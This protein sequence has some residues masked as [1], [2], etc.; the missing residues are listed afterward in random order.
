MLTQYYT[1]STVA[2][3]P[4]T[5]QQNFRLAD[6]VWAEFGDAARS[7]HTDRSRLIVEFIMWYLRSPN[8]RLPVRPER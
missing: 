1:V 3:M 7:M 2:T 5:K 4:P 6:E 8:A